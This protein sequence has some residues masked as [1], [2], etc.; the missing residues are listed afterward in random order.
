[1]SQHIQFMYQ[2]VME[3]DLYL[4]NWRRS[5]TNNGAFLFLG[6]PSLF[7]GSESVLFIS[8]GDSLTPLFPYLTSVSFVRRFF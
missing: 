2:T 3:H 7:V 1:M 5:E 6:K 8:V 4:V